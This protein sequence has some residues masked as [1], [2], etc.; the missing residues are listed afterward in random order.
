MK[1]RVQQAW[2]VSGTND[3]KYEDE[4][5]KDICELITTYKCHLITTAQ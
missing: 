1:T 2:R 3:P 5:S 4:V